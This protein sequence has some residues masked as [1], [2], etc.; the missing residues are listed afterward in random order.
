MSTAMTP[1]SQRRD[2]EVYF[3]AAPEDQSACEEII[4]HLKPIIRSSPFPIE[5]NSDFNI[6]AGTEKEK[7]KQRLLE[8]DIVL[9]LISVDF[10]NN[11]EVYGRNQK[12]IER[13]N[14]DETAMISILVRNF[15]WKSTP[16]VNLPLVPKNL[17]PL[18]NKQF[19]NSPD[20]AVTAVVSDIYDSINE[21]AR[22]QP[23]AIQPV[24]VA[25]VKPAPAP[26]APAE[27]P[28]MQTEITDLG[29]EPAPSEALQPVPAA[30][31][32]PTAAMEMPAAQPKAEESMKEL[33]PAV[34]PMHVAE[35]K[36]APDLKPAPVVPVS[37]GTGQASASSTIAMDWRGKYYRAVVLKRAGAILLDQLLLL[38]VPFFLLGLGLGITGTDISE[39][40]L[41]WIAMFIY[42]VV[43]PIME[44]SKWQGTIGKRIMKLQITDREGDRVTFLR[45]FW[46]NIMRT[47]VFYSYF[48]VVPLIYQYIRFNK[49]RKLFHDELS[50]TVIGE[51]LTGSAAAPIAV[52]AA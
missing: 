12:V 19:W 1:R 24:P 28:R 5:V 35:A 3:L 15:M 52:N 4:K 26:Q 10:I 13:Y 8:A 48:L 20:D 42:F 27:A 22:S 14:K 44:S 50:G 7:H 11:D 31:V 37:A 33:P 2:I 41:N 29:K 21:L 47:V 18:N 38:F 32:K 9:A 51:R 43:M 34:Q 30:E 17:Q 45:A 36:R 25:P 49:T 16:F 6:P 46:R 40:G 23:E 39:T